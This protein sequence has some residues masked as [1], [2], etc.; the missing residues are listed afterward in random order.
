MSPI[1]EYGPFLSG[2]VSS[3]DGTRIGRQAIG[4]GSTDV[5]I[6]QRTGIVF[7]RRGSATV[8]DTYGSNVGLLEAKWSSKFR[9]MFALNSPSLSDGYRTLAALVTNDSLREGT[10]YFRSTNS[11]GSNQQPCLSYGN[12]DYTS[13][14]MSYHRANVPTYFSTHF[15]GVYA[16]AKAWDIIMS[17]LWTEHATIRFTRCNDN[18]RRRLLFPG[19][20]RVL[21]ASGKVVAPNRWGTP[22]QWDTGFN[23]AV[24][25]GYNK[26]RI[27]PLGPMGSAFPV[28]Y[29]STQG[30]AVGN[31]GPIDGKSGA[32]YSVVPR[33]ADGSYGAPYIPNP[34]L[35]LVAVDPAHPT[36]G[37]T[38]PN[39]VLSVTLK[40]PV[41]HGDVVARIVCRTQWVDLST[42]PQP[43]LSPYLL[44][45]VG[46]IE[47]NT[48][49]DFVDR[50][51]N[52]GITD[53]PTIIR[54]DRVM[55]PRARTAWTMDGRVVFGGELAPS[56]CAIQLNPWR[57]KTASGPPEVF[58]Y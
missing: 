34:V 39:G 19:S 50:A 35:D 9:Q 41:M 18:H 12:L 6:D 45:V 3:V 13:V 22:A 10:L 30:G 14:Y 26:E 33:Y 49:M 36:T 25:S 7:R 28:R 47:N 51:T 21:Q 27:R 2:Y 52:A 46:S 32:L 56:P 43:A 37:A 11:G 54:Y 44:Y 1:V 48:A 20:R 57:V 16:G 31:P 8:F 4:P 29:S 53:D 24:G 40:V 15:G 5:A 17:P 55:A 23:D 38:Y 58:T 42:T